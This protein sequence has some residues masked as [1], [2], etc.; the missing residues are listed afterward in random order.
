MLAEIA[1]FVEDRWDLVSLGLVSFELLEVA[2]RELMAQ[3]PVKLDSAEQ[4]AQL[5]CHEVRPHSMA[6][7]SFLA[8]D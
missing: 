7:R 5:F 6:P 8:Y 1:F 3:R 4:M 2:M